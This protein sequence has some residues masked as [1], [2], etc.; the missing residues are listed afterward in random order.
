MT[1]SSDEDF[2]QIQASQ[3]LF[4]SKPVPSTQI[5]RILDAGFNDSPSSKI[6]ISENR[7]V[8][9]FKTSSGFPYGQCH[10]IYHVNNHSLNIDS[11]F[12]SI[13]IVYRIGRTKFGG[14]DE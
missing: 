4:T 5:L 13:D 9:S 7:T 11:V 12:L 14:E 3:R 1:Q 2:I 8:V 10:F 6:K